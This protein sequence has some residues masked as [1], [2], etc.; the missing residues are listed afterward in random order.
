VLNESLLAR[1]LAPI[2]NLNKSHTCKVAQTSL[3]LEL[4]VAS[5]TSIT[6]GGS[7]SKCP[8]RSSK[9][10]SGMVASRS[11]SDWRRQNAGHMI[12]AIRIW[13]VILSCLPTLVFHLPP[14]ELERRSF[15]DPCI[16]HRTWVPRGKGI[17]IPRRHPVCL[18]PCT[19]H[20]K[21]TLG[22]THG[23]R[24]HSITSSV[25]SGGTTTSP[26][27]LNYPLSADVL[28]APTFLGGREASHAFE[29]TD[30]NGFS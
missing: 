8:C 22:G 10:R 30:R 11:R 5:I 14:P 24:M 13:W 9:K 25:G 1:E 28:A 20:P 17:L 7:L 12:V 23:L 15:V 21:A 27:R 3:C 18:K 26:R 29:A 2:Q 4:L 19:L 16:L 6:T